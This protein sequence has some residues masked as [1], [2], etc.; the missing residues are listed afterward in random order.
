MNDRR[1]DLGTAAVLLVFGALSFVGL[2]GRPSFQAIRSVDV[3]HLIGTG[4]CFGAA[5]VAFASSLRG[6]R[7][8]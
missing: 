1:R 7:R 8:E 4:M 6:S 2:L 3:V 5:I